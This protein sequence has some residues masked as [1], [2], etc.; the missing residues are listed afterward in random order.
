MLNHDET[1]IVN[2]SEPN[3]FNIVIA[4]A[5]RRLYLVEWFREA[6]N[7]LGLAGQVITT[8]ASSSSTALSAGDRAIVMPP[9]TSVDYEEAMIAM[10]R[11]YKPRILVSLNDYE[12]ENMA[13]GLGARL[14]SLGVVTPGVPS[15]L[16]STVT[17]KYACAAY[18]TKRGI[19]APETKLGS[20]VIGGEEITTDCEEFIVKHRWGSGSSGLKI[21]RRDEVESAVEQ[22]M[23]GAP[24]RGL[25]TPSESVVVQP[26]IQGAEYGLDVVGSLNRGG[27]LIGVLA[28]RKLR[29]RA[30][31][32]D[33]AT[34]VDSARFRPL[35]KALYSALEPVGLIDVDVLVNVSG[36]ESVIDI[37]PRFGG[38]YPFNHVAGAS[39]PKLYVEG[40]RS[41]TE[42]RD[43]LAYMRGVTGGKHEG[44]R[45]VGDKASGSKNVEARRPN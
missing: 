6:L 18:L 20:D 25:A 32:T 5:G 8:D 41:G 9:Y 21:A 12:I 10:V 15:G 34:T 7:E 11:A 4:S 1:S 13:N 43:H 39:V 38:G 28:R 30:G 23:A 29:M 26:K 27:G 42:K 17:D 37:N 24:S 22:S 44:I 45:K 2:R 16:I 31:E 3:A 33:Q 14:E 35:G 40:V 36:E 19:S